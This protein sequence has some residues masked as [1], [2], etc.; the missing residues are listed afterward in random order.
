MCPLVVDTISKVWS[1]VLCHKYLK[2]GLI[3]RPLSLLSKVRVDCFC[4]SFMPK[5]MFESVYVRH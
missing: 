3:M 5:E 4:L 1:C 2:L